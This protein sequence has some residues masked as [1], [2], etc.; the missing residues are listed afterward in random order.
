MAREPVRHGTLSG[1]NR[2][3]RLGEEPCSRCVAG[4]RA[5][6]VEDAEARRKARAKGGKPSPKSS[7]GAS[8]QSHKPSLKPQMYLVALEVVAEREV[9]VMAQSKEE[10][11]DSVMSQAVNMN[12]GAKWVAEWDMDDLAGHVVAVKTQEVSWTEI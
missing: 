3:K 10:A 4:A 9:M 8:R 11:I 6:W 12:L 7:G 1:Y 5:K 2:H